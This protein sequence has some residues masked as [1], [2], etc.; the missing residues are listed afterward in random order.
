MSR[1]RFPSAS[2]GRLSFTTDTVRRGVAR[3]RTS[4]FPSLPSE[5][6]LTAH[7]EGL[8]APLEKLTSHSEGTVNEMQDEFVKIHGHIGVLGREFTLL[9]YPPC[10]RVFHLKPCS[11]PLWTNSFFRDPRTDEL[12]N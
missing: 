5:D 8:L 4:L 11:P 12:L 6:R 10:H 3:R 9:Y 2:F 7:R 1:P